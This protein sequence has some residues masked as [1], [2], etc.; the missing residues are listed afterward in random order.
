MRAEPDLMI[1]L[2]L[3]NEMA[4]VTPKDLL[5]FAGEIPGR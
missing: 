5:E 1:A 4:V 2:A 3:A